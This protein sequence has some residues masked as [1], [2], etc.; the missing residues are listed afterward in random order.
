MVVICYLSTA[1]LKFR[2]QMAI[3]TTAEAGN[4]VLFLVKSDLGEVAWS[5]WF[6]V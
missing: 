1:I 2:K 5:V 6:L 4:P 3:L